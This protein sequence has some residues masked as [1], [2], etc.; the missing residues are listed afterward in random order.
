M[1]ETIIRQLSMNRGNLNSL[2]KEIIKRI[3]YFPAFLVPAV[4]SDFIYSSL[5][6]PTLFSYVNNPLPPQ[7]K[8]KLAIALSSYLG[9]FYFTICHSCTLYSWGASP[10]E[11]L[12]LAKIEFP[13]TEK[14]AI[15]ELKLVEDNWQDWQNNSQLEAILLRCSGFIFLNSK[16]TP[17][18]CNQLKSLLGE[19]YY[20]YLILLLGYIK[21]CHEW[22]IAN[23]TISHREDR[24]S[25]MYLGS[26]L[27][28]EIEL[29]KFFGNGAD[30]ISPVKHRP[31]CSRSHSAVKRQLFI[32]DRSKL[33]EAESKLKLV[34]KTTKTGYYS[35]DLIANRVDLC[36]LGRTILG[37][38]SFDGSYVS[39]WRSI[40]LS[41]RESVDLEIARA[42]Q[43]RQDFD[44][45][46]R[47]IKFDRETARIRNFGKLQYNAEGQPVSVSGIVTDIT[48]NQT[49]LKNLDLD[50]HRL[51]KQL[52]INNHLLKLDTLQSIEFQTIFDLL[53]YYIFV[54]D[55]KTQTISSMNSNMARSLSIGDSQT[56]RGK[57]LA[58]CFAPE[59]VDLIVQQ[60]QQITID[61]Q[62]LRLKQ[63][64][65]L[66]DGIHYFDMAIVPLVD[67]S[68][69][70]YALLHTY[71]D[72]PDL[73]DTKE[74]LSQRTIQ[75]EAANREL[76]SF[77]YSVSHDLQAPLR[78][79][80][81]F[82]QVLWERSQTDL[83]DL[84]K[85][86][87]E[88]IQV[89]SQRMSELIDALLRLSRVTR[90]QMK[91]VNVN[92]SAIALDLVEEL[93]LS[94]PER[95]VEVTIAPN[96]QA[97]G[98]PQLLKIV[99][100]N[101]F[102]NAWKYTSKRSQG[103]IEF[104]YISNP[105]Q[106]VTYYLRDN[107]A[108]FDSNYADKLFTAFQRLHSEEEFPGTGIGLATV[109]RIIYRHGGRV[110]AHGE[111]DR[112]AT[113]YFSL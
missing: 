80:N 38:E 41:Q 24:R 108:G 9:I 107:G 84:A 85:H 12:A 62:V 56:V 60:H 82:S 58:E 50:R 16:A 113:I 32:D 29:A 105:Q 31:C 67:E 86:Y 78:I 112:G 19:V 11:I 61:R 15:A 57:T 6:K 3:G 43:A 81:G 36:H 30:A 48:C 26:L 89:N 42:I 87:L 92:L 91:S 2:K 35:W 95:Q 106:P 13:Q 52:P 69:S 23:P 64:M 96:L 4:D 28:E 75:L 102:N 14:L 110:W 47:I 70:I 83:D 5:L 101:L 77:S 25:Q 71:S 34:L 65:T 100:T 73:A 66:I 55:L 53:P 10:R 109:Q 40:Y 111:C 88:R 103:Q 63:K 98:D 68:G 90:S 49:N 8:E 94:N 59:C 39:F 74:A 93:R 37:L 18:L 76:K 45:N 104:G 22:V 17:D 20:H 44:L 46:Y 54:V 1:S 21:L 7:F 97:Q 99:L 51:R 27:L 79:I 72:L 33:T